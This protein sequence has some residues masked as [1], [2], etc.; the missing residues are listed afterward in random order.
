M[1]LQLGWGSGA[2]APS[3]EQGDTHCT[4]RLNSFSRAF[5]DGTQVTRAPLVL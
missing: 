3:P 2:Q 1:S 5:M 4:A